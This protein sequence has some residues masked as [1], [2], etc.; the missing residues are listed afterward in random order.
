MALTRAEAFGTITA[1]AL[2]GNTVIVHKLAHTVLQVL[3]HGDVWV[4]LWS[5][6]VLGVA[7]S[8]LACVSDATALR[9]AWHGMACACCACDTCCSCITLLHTSILAAATP[10]K[11]ISNNNT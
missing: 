6:C 3:L 10:C 8:A 7:V 11:G 9:C 2:V 1:F 4:L 5:A